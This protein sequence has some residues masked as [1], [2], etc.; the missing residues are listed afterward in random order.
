MTATRNYFLLKRLTVNPRYREVVYALRIKLIKRRK[1]G[2]IEI[3]DFI[4]LMTL[5]ID[6]GQRHH[7]L[8]S[9]SCVNDAS[10]YPRLITADATIIISCRMSLLS[11]VA[12]TSSGVS[13][14]RNQC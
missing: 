6:Q 14:T 2:E 12:T 4:D 5:T 1:N 3:Y 9:D 10:K 13:Q 11:Q 7:N 8:L